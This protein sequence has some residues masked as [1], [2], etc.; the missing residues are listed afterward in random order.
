MPGGLPSEFTPEVIEMATQY[1]NNYKTHGHIIPSIVG[2]AD[3][4][5]R[6]ESTI[7]KWAAEQSTQFSGILDR[8][9]TR[10]H[11]V[12]L[13]GGLGDEMNTQITKLVLG[14]H[15]YHDMSKQELT[16]TDGGPVKTEGKWTVEFVNATPSTS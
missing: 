15:G 12:L 9:R 3:V 5:N 7:Y 4:L 2:L 10:Q 16:G 6:S 8:I 14:K 11:L 13:N 1:L